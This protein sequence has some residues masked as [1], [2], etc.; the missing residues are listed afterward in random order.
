MLKNLVLTV[1]IMDDINNSDEANEDQNEDQGDGNKTLEELNAE[2]EK[3]TANNDNLNKALKAERAKSKKA[4]S[5]A[6]DVDFNQVID[7]KFKEQSLA[8]KYNGEGLPKFDVVELK[9]YAEEQGLDYSKVN[10]EAL[11]KL[12][13]SDELANFNTKK[14]LKKNQGVVTADG[15]KITMADAKS[16]L[17][18][19]KTPQEINEIM[20]LK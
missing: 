7:R 14:V 12:K 17:A 4:D 16:K 8:N 5:T 6:G 13:H 9:E 10:P 2:L 18:S 1:K 11:Y 19:A 20:G 15:K 3:L